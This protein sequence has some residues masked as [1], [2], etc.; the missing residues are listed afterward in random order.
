MAL[1]GD[2]V[3]RYQEISCN[4]VLKDIITMKC[5]DKRKMCSRSQRGHFITHHYTLYKLVQ[6]RVQQAQDMTILFFQLALSDMR[7]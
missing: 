4:M 5:E 6:T 3:K 2:R 1:S 7:Q